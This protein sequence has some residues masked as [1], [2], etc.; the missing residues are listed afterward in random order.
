L[1]VGTI[2]HFAPFQTSASVPTALPE[3]STRPPA[4][5]QADDEVQATPDSP[6]NTGPDGLGVAWMA[7]LVPFHRSARVLPFPELPTAVH[8]ERDAH[9]TLLRKPPPAGLGVGSMAQLLP[10]HRSARVVPSALPPTAVHAEG[11][12]HEMLLRAPPPA[13]LGVG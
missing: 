3:L 2:R 1:K 11:E 9:D 13:G 10:F 4:A 8:T 12:V 7:Q 5:M 6:V